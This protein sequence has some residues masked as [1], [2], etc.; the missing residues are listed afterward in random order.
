MRLIITNK[1]RRHNVNNSLNL[2]AK[3]QIRLLH[4]FRSS[5]RTFLHQQE[6]IVEQITKEQIQAPLT[7]VDSIQE[8]FYS[9]DD[10]LQK[11]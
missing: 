2:S 10:L 6:V 5:S 9:F 1:F 7:P 8:E 11:E 4:G 3:Q